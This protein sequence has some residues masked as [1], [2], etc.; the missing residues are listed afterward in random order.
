M[1]VY[2]FIPQE[3]KN[4]NKR[5]YT[6][7]GA[8]LCII[9]IIIIESFNF[10]EVDYL[11]SFLKFV[12]ISLII[13][14]LYFVFSSITEKEKLYGV[15]SGEIILTDQEVIL[16]KEHFKLD[17]ILNITIKSDDYE[18]KFS[19][20]LVNTSYP[21]KSA[22]VDNYFEIKLNDSSVRKVQFKQNY[23]DEF[24]K[25]NRDML[26]YFC[27]LDKISFLALTVILN[28]DDYDEIQKLKK[29]IDK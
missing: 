23:E 12:G 7:L 6:I 19:F 1:S 20:V 14:W 9:V 5:Y 4:Y 21:C 17:E 29:L 3:K 2:I 25:K 26:I 27:K 28:I 13:L 22:G 18:D 11:I 8:L 15:L 10:L 16:G 24:I